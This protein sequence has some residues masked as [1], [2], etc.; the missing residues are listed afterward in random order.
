M[1]TSILVVALSLGWLWKGK[2]IFYNAEQQHFQQKI[3]L[4]IPKDLAFAGERVHFKNPTA[5]QLFYRELR[6]NTYKNSSSK[7]IKRNAKRILPM[8]EKVFKINHV[9]DDFKYIAIAESNLR[10]DVKSSQGA[11]GIWQLTKPTAIA[12]G[13]K[14]NDEIDERLNTLKA[15]KAACK[16]IKFAKKK[17][18]TWTLAAVAYNRGAGG[19]ERAM[20]KQE[21][22]SYYDLDLNPETEKYIYKIVAFKQLFGSS[23]YSH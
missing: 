15:T 18:G 23:T 9:P 3:I 17:F 20:A 4:A 10:N 1:L 13:L 22:T 5:Y 6:L 16:Y 21:M 14:V 12:L 7:T 19:L 8:I 2:S 11:T